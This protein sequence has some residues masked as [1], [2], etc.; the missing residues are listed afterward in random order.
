MARHFAS[1]PGFGA[2]LPQVSKKPVGITRLAQTILFLALPA[3]A[4][5]YLLQLVT[6]VTIVTF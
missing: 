6:L 3:H 1:T 2:G 4:Y 5:K